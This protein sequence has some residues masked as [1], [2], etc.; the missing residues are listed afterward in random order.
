MLASLFIVGEAATS[1]FW[2]LAL[3][4]AFCATNS[5]KD[6]VDVCTISIAMAVWPEVQRLRCAGDEQ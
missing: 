1:L 3:A 4:A 6:L 2:P 5:T